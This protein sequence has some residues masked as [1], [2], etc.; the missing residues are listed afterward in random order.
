MNRKL[1]DTNKVPKSRVELHLHLGGSV[2]LST[3]WEIAHK[4]GLKLTP[5]GTFNELLDYCVIKKP[6]K[7]IDFLK[8]LSHYRKGDVEALERCAYELCEDEAKEGVLYFELRTSP[9]LSSNTVKKR[10]NSPVLSV[11]DANACSPK[12]VVEAVLR[13]L[14]RGQRDF[15]IK[16]SLILSCVCGF[17]EW[18]EEVLQLAQEFKGKG[19]VGIDIAGQEDMNSLSTHSFTQNEVMAFKA[20]KELGIHRTVHAGEAGPAANVEFALDS[21]FA[22]RIGHGYSVINDE[23]IYKR[24]LSEGVHF[25]VCPYSSYFTG[26][27]LPMNRNP[28]VVF[29]EDGANFS[30]SKD[31]PTVTAVT[32]DDEYE[33]C[34]KLGLNEMHIT[35]AVR[36]SLFKMTHIIKI[37]NINAMKASFLPQQEKDDLLKQLYSVELHLHLEGSVRLTTIWE[38]SQKKGI[39]LTPNGTY[40]ELRDV[41]IMKKPETLPVCLNLI[42]KY[43]DIFVGD[44]DILERIAYEL[45]EDEAKQ[46]VLY[47]E[48][49]MSPQLSSNTVQNKWRTEGNFTDD[50]NAIETLNPVNPC[51]PK[52]VI[53]SVLKGLKRGEKDFGVYSSLILSCMTSFPE[54][55]KEVVELAQEFKDK[56]VVGIDIAGPENQHSKET[57]S[58]NQD[59]IDTFCRAK[60]LGIHRTV[61]A[62]EVGPAANVEF[63]VERLHAQRIGHGYNG[64]LDSAVYRKCLAASIH[65]ETCPHSSYYTGGV[66][67]SIRHPILM[68]AEENAN[69]S[70]N[71]DDPTVFDCTLDSEYEFLTRLGL[72]ELHFIRANINAMKSSFLPQKRK[73]ELLKQFIKIY[74]INIYTVCPNGWTQFENKCFLFYT[75]NI[76][77][78]ISTISALI[79]SSTVKEKQHFSYYNTVLT[80]LAVVQLIIIVVYRKNPLS[81]RRI[82]KMSECD[83]NSVQKF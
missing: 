67:P 81:Y 14:K 73:E 68:L 9:H 28:I 16:T 44:S 60:E 23:T 61:H 21:M 8:I 63:A 20:A 39:K 46:G 53:E 56:G 31:D 33:Y 37:T 27:V 48:T 79:S 75:D 22:E 43:Y 64:A 3:V 30:I 69:F 29:A 25:E 7:L 59:V 83:T 65:F 62:G 15:G 74:M 78:N 71:K 52:Q 54:F 2:R 51:T 45:C 82:V 49:R 40:D 4:K 72:N 70:I 58:F 42:A 47:F 38:Y 34:R 18:S 55:N 24:C 80:V 66:D 77:A 13:G 5:N 19:V 57:H 76:S 50:I 32:L 6:G 36:L 1:I 35:R 26:S 41:F 11:S 12:Q 10:H 17:P